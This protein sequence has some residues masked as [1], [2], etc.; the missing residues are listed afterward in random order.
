MKRFSIS[1][2]TRETQIKTIIPL[3]T[4]QKG[5][6]FK[7]NKNP[8]H[9]QGCRRPEMPQTLLVGVEIVALLLKTV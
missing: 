5:L 4:Y 1:L 7:K 9:W 3:H 6:N 8:K 2:V